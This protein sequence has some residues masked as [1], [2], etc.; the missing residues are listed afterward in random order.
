M[1]IHL[2][3]YAINKNS[4]GFMKNYNSVSDFIGSK[5]SLKFVIRYL[6]K[7]RNAYKALLMKEIKDLTIK[8]ILSAQSHLSHQYR[9]YQIDVYEN[10]ACFGILSF[11]TMLKDKCKPYLL[12][13]NHTPS[14][15]TDSPLDE[16]IK[17]QVILNILTCSGCVRSKRKTTATSTK[18][19]TISGGLCPRKRPSHCK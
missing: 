7:T 17:G 10:S 16:K 6:K 4:L 15:G 9:R 19:E 12:E 8:V 11:D 2:T 18:C 5:R 13:I 3:N 1:S 14:F